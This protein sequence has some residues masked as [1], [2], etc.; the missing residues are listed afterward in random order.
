MSS[1][2]PWAPSNSSDW[3]RARASCSSAATSA[4]IG[5]I[6][7]GERQRVVERLREWHRVALE[8]LR[9]HEIVEL[10]QRLELRGEAIGVEEVLQADRAPRDL[11]LVG[12]ADAAAGRPDLRVAHRAFA[13]LVERDVVRKDQR[14]R[15][16][17]LEARTHGDAGALELADL[18][19]Q[20][21][22]REHDAVA[23]V[24]GDAGPQDAGRNE[25]QH[26][27]PAA[28]DERVAGVVPALE[29]HDAV[30]V[31]GQPVDDLAL[32]FIAPLGADDNDV[33]AHLSQ[34]PIR[35]RRCPRA[36]AGPA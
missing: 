22:R 19:Q 7:A 30:G 31:L 4:T 27:L 21:R 14:A 16:R 3:P 32:A 28:D 23:D 33:L 35:E 24:D 20:R 13:R 25:A 36:A 11:V 18:L 9:Q 8:I 17:D 12:G 15:R 29:A 2:A 34:T 1:S 6:A 5:S 26:G 10:E